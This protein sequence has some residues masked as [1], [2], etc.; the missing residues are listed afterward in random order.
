[1]KKKSTLKIPKQIL[2]RNILINLATGNYTCKD[3][4]TKVNKQGENGI[5]P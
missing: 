2:P 3:R 1:M 4:H 5:V